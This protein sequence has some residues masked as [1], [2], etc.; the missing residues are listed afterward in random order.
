MDETFT[1]IPSK[2]TDFTDVFS[3]KLAAKLR[4]HMK[5]NNYTIELVN[6]WQSPYGFIYSLDLVGLEI[7][8]TYIEN[9]L[10]NGF[11]KL[12]RFSVGVSIF[13]A[14]KPDRSLRLCTDY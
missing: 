14:K 8:K 6:D 1:K 5:I 7:I 13:F 10:A 9:N 3:P 2:Y 11:I 4:E 12:S